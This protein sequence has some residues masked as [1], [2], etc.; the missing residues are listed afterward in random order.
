MTRFIS[1]CVKVLRRRR[2]RRG[3]DR[4]KKC[5]GKRVPVESTSPLSQ[6]YFGIPYL[7]LQLECHLQGSSFS[8][9]G[10]KFGP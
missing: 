6:F 8:N 2:G 1:C 9:P 3:R 7:L 10:T 4:G 5:N